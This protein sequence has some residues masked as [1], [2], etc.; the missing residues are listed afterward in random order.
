[1]DIIVS[2]NAVTLGLMMSYKPGGTQLSDV[3]SALQGGTGLRCVDWSPKVTARE[4]KPSQF[5]FCVHTNS[6]YI[7]YNT[8]YN[9]LVR[10]R[11]C[12][13]EQYERKKECTPELL[14][15]FVENGLWVCVEIDELGR[16]LDCAELILRRHDRV[17]NLTVATTL[18]CNANCPYCYERGVGQVDMLP[19]SSE[20]IIAFIL[21]NNPGFGVNFTWF[22]GEPLMNTPLIDEICDAMTFREIPF[23]S[24]MITNGSL[25]RLD[26]LEKNVS[27]WHLESVQ[28]SLDGTAKVY[29]EIK[30]YNTKSQITYYLILRAIRKLADLKVHV[31]IRLNIA[32]HNAIDIFNLLKELDY[33]YSGNDWI[34]YYP[35]FVEGTKDSFRPEEKRD[36]LVKLLDA[37]KDLKKLTLTDRLYSLPKTHSCHNSDPRAFTIDT[38]GNIMGCEHYVGHAER[39][40]ANLDNVSEIIDP[41]LQRRPLRLQCRECVFLP[42]CFG[43]CQAY[44]DSGD[45][46]CRIEKYLIPAY[47]SL[48]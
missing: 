12:E 33:L 5:N 47:L 32:K 9:S 17:L 6:G 27:R 24:F 8:L 2:A 37:V 39:A 45:D 28:I 29:H 36:Y 1:M 43:G 16:Y 11:Q 10:M 40:F 31:T 44:C 4:C 15:S 19:G 7:V 25:F 41:R 14:R 18:R 22:G 42:K 38:Y 26:E 21:N 30:K 46:P 13:Y 20:K 3:L 23:T 34:Q 48:L 35:A